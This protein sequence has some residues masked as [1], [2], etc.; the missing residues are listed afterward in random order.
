MPES[1]FYTLFATLMLM[2]FTWFG[3]V[4]WLHS[5][6]RNLHPDTYLSLGSPTLFWN[7]SPRTGWLLIKY[8]FRPKPIPTEDVSL[9]RMLVTMKVFFVTYAA[10]LGIL[11]TAT[12]L[13]PPAF[14]VVP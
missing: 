4:A 1:L 5:R 8:I 9:Q 14:T 12:V 10:L 13:F 2:A 6:L 11:I 3:L 7:N